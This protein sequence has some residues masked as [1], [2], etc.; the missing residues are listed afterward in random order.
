MIRIRSELYNKLLTL[1]GWKD[2]V[3]G[4]VGSTLIRLYSF[5]GDLLIYRLNVLANENYLDTTQIKDNMLKIIKLLNYK[6]K[7]AVPSHGDLTLYIEQASAA[8]IVIP[9]GTRLSTPDNILFYTVYEDEIVAGDKEVSVKVVQG[10]QKEQF[11][12]SNGTKNQEFIL[13]SDS[14]DYYVGGKIWPNSQYEYSGLKVYVDDV[15]W[16]ETDSL[17][18][19]GPTDTDYY[20]EQFSDYAIKVIF[21]DD[22]LG[23]V[24]PSGLTIKFVYN[25]NIGK[26]GNVNAGTVTQVSDTISDVNT[27]PVSVYVNQT[28]SFL[29]GGDPED[30]E[31]IRANAPNY[32]AAGDRAITNTDI[33]ALINSNFSNILDIYIRAEEDGDTPNFKQFNQITIGLLLADVDGTPL[34]PSATGEN[35]LSFYASV[36]E[37]IK[38]KRSITVWRKYLIPEAVEILFKVDYRK[39]E[40]F[41]DSSVRASIQGAV[42]NYLLTNGRLGATLKSSDL[43]Y[44]IENLQG[45]DWCYLYM[46][47]SID[48]SYSRDNI[49]LSETQFPV[50]GT[51]A[52]LLMTQV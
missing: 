4:G 47:K 16:T 20:V 27:N 46:K 42:E 36:D 30:I 3:E 51:G 10:I 18:N 9:Q 31:S 48:A 38:Q 33:I 17:V 14:T 15:L 24:P 28:S 43:I 22:E 50:K 21:G 29:N 52:Y 25:L 12:T 35:Y 2:A 23:K 8:N 7:R 41:S 26:Y 44:D 39:Y 45:V 5:L 49:V 1:P 19:S 13:N 11:F 6:V 40:G 34:V 37:L 32:Y